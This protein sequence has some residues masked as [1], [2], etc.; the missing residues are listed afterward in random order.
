MAVNPILTSGINGV[1]SGME[2]MAD[3]AQEIAE[4]NLTSSDS[5]PTQT[6]DNPA[7]AAEVMI[8]LKV[9][10]RQV[11]ASAKIVQTADEVMGFLIDRL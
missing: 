6:L 9:Y 11:Q 8:D 7:E 2:G 1:R 4:F 10:Q 5:P 3:A